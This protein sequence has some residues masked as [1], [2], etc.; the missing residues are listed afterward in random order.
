MLCAIAK[1]LAE[2]QVAEIEALE[3]QTGLTLVA[4]SCRSLDPEREERL[5][6]IEAELGSALQT[7]P[8]AISEEQLGRIRGLEGEMGLSLVAVQI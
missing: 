6:Q 2:G 7:E 5:R 8:A 1:N 3:Q 4:F